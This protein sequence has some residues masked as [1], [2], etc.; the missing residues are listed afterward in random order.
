MFF[1][2]IKEKKGN[3]K[4]KKIPESAAYIA[5]SITVWMVNMVITSLH[6]FQLYF[7]DKEAIIIMHIVEIMA[8]ISVFI[9]IMLVYYI[10][11]MNRHIQRINENEREARVMQKMFYEKLLEKEEDTRK[12]RHDMSNQ[13]I[14]LQ[15]LLENGKTE[16][17]KKHMELLNHSMKEIHEKVYVTGNDMLDIMINYY[18]D[19]LNKETQIRVLGGMSGNIKAD[20]VEQ[21][22]IFSNVIKNAIEEINR[23]EFEKPFITIKIENGEEMVG[24]IVENS[25]E[26]KKNKKGKFQTSKRDIKN[27]GIGTSNIK[28]TVKKCKG[29]CIL[30]Y[31]NGTF[32]SK[33]YLPR[34]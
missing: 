19:H 24:I 5:I 10:Y 1:S 7:T 30:Q 20:S 34:E 25:S 33:I 3:I 12:F 29:V 27:H 8:L 31:E 14:Y 17:L 22:V 2:I 18:K 15:A 32:T 13:L 23:G 11:N 9:L 26:E 6:F 28:E 21:C 16:E 4:E